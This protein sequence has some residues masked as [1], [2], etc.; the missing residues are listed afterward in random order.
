MQNFIVQL[1]EG[2]FYDNYNDKCILYNLFTQNNN[3]I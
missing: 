3:L 1:R 2:E